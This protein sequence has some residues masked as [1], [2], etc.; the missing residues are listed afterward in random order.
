MNTMLKILSEQSILQ[1]DYNPNFPYSEQL[2]F[3]QMITLDK[4]FSPMQTL[5][6][7]FEI[8]S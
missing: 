1:W 2:S 4:K 3:H 6:L 5:N 7:R 8:I